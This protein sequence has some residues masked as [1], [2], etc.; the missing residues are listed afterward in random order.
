VRHLLTWIKIAGIKDGGYL[1]PHADDIG[2][3][4]DETRNADYD[5]FLGWMK[6]LV[7][8]ILGKDKDG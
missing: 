2:K 4:H 5:R 3:E 6:Y 7:F 8:D 1:F